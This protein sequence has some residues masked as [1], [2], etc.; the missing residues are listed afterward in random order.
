VEGH[1]GAAGVYKIHKTETSI[2]FQRL[3]TITQRFN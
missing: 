1:S 3:S 2:H